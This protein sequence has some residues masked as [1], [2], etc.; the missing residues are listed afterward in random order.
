MA[1]PWLEAINIRGKD[2]TADALLT[3]RKRADYLLRERQAHYHF[4]VKGNPPGLLEDLKFYF[5]DRGQPQFV[6]HTSP[7]HGRLETRKIWTTTELHGDLNFPHVGQAFLVEPQGTEKKT[8][9]HSVQIAYGLTSRPSQQADP[10]HVLRVNRGHWSIQNSCHY[11]LDWTF[12]ED[13]SRIRTG[14]G[15]E[16]LT[17]LRRF[18]IGMIKSK[19]AGSVAQKMRQLTRQVR[20]VF[21]YLGMTENAR[22]GRR[23]K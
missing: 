4:T 1:I 16:N 3:Q 18:A 9:E 23:G 7:D 12:D 19:G 5:R 14:Y 8:G 2:L 6:E 13:R 17:R 21:D 15:P 10:R 22:V 20:Q 11:V